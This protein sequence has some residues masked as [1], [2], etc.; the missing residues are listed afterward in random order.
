MAREADLLA[1]TRRNLQ[2]EA[3]QHGIKA[4]LS[5]REIV[6]QLLALRA[7]P[8]HAVDESAACSGTDPD[9]KH[10]TLDTAIDHEAKELIYEKGR[11]SD[12][13]ALA[14]RPALGLPR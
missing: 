4:N 2:A 7:A 5:S 11:L 10:K 8:D 13:A 14:E 12:A 9:A 1:M 6:R 3:K